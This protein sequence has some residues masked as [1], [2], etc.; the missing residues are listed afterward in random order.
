MWYIYTM[1]ITQP[2]KKMTSQN[3]QAN[4]MELKKKIVLSEVT[5]VPED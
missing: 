5:Q 4:G 2:F 3:L 1:S